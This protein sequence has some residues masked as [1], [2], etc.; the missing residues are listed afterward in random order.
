MLQT[1]LVAVPIKQPHNEAIFLR[2]KSEVEQLTSAQ[3]NIKIAFFFNTPIEASVPYAPHAYAR[4][5]LLDNY[6][7]DEIDYVLW[8][9]SDLV[10]LPS[11]LIDSLYINP[12]SIVAPLALIEPYSGYNSLFY[13]TEGFRELDGEK[14]KIHPPYFR[15]QLGHFYQLASVG[16][17]YLI[18]ADVY[19]FVKY[20]AT[21]GQTEHWSVCEAA[22]KRGYQIV[23]NTQVVVRHAELPKYGEAWH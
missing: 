18:P 1:V 16:C 23:C 11:Y 10:E 19:K 5:S 7:T 21:R 3:F 6:L 17:C 20:S 13:D 15:N 2:L 8:I 4:N 9:D 12:Y 14:A 22:R